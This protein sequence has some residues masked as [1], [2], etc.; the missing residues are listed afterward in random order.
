MRY[1]ESNRGHAS[2]VFSGFVGG[3]ATT[4]IDTA[5]FPWSAREGIVGL[6][7]GVAHT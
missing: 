4:L 6:R 2:V 3:D 5:L 7:H 1:T